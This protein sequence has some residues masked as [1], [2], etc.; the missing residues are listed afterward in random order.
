MKWF[1][2]T[3][4]KPLGKVKVKDQAGIIQLRLSISKV[5]KELPFEWNDYKA[6]SEPIKE[7]LPLH[8]VRC[9]IYQCRNLRA[10]D[11]DGASDP[12][13]VI[14]NI[15]GEDVKTKVIK[16]TVNPLVYSVK[17]VDYDFDDINHAPPI[18][19]NIYDHDDGLFDSTPDYMGT[20]VIHLKDANV[21][22]QLFTFKKLLN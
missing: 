14:N 18:V 8:Q 2:M 19:I 7:N 9:Y 5:D 13:V 6:W 4:N 12:F 22:N 16:N 21:H 17:Q 10:V 20:S 15:N 11:A 1:N 3:L